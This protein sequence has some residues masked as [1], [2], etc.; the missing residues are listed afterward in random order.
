MFEQQIIFR[1]F[2]KPQLVVFRSNLSLEYV[3]CRVLIK[4]FLAVLANTSCAG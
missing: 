3:D 4:D 2:D 1:Y